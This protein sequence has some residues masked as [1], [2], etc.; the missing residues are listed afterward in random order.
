MQGLCQHS[1]KVGHLIINHTNAY[2]SM[3]WQLHHMTEQ[4]QLMP[5]MTDGLLFI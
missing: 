4:C 5:L 3:V 2:L 1:D